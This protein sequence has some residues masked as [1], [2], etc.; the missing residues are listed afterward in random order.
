T[1]LRAPGRASRAAPPSSAR[2][3]CHQERQEQIEHV[4]PLERPARARASVR[5]ARTAV[6]ELVQ[7]EQ[8]LAVRIELRGLHLDGS[9]EDVEMP[10]L[11][12]WEGHRLGRAV[13]EGDDDLLGDVRG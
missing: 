13:L 12:D 7:I 2:S 5:L 10:A 6:V 1:V 3:L 8:E 9:L 11:L 4:R